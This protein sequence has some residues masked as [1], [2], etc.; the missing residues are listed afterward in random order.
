MILTPKFVHFSEVKGLDYEVSVLYC[1]RQKRLLMMCKEIEVFGMYKHHAYYW[2]GGEYGLVFYEFMENESLHD[3]LHEKP[4]TWNI[5]FN[6]VV[7][8]AK[9]LAYVHNNCDPPIV[10]QV[11][12]SYS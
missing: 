2:I 3:I 7:G 9:G 4:L 1:L 5:I 11:I 8:I 6:I 12:K 10:H